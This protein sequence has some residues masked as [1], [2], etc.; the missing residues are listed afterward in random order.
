MVILSYLPL[1][2]YLGDD[3]LEGILGNYLISNLYLWRVNQLQGHKFNCVLNINKL[4]KTMIS[5]QQLRILILSFT[6]G[7]VIFILFQVILAPPSEKPAAE[8]QAQTK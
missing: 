3:G 1:P 8:L 6:F 4:F 5:W 2:N 7:G